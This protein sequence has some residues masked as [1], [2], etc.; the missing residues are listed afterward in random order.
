MIS[1]QNKPS[2]YFVSYDKNDNKVEGET[3]QCIHCQA[4]W[5]YKPGSGRKYGFCLR[6]GGVTCN[7]PSCNTCKQC[8][9]FSEAV[10]DGNYHMVNGIYVKR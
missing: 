6:C 1:G 7:K 10:Y 8:A 9:P 5:I 4:T 2:G 3:R